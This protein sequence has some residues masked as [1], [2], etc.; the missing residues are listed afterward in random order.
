MALFDVRRDAAIC[1]KLRDQPTLR[2]HGRL[3]V[4]D[5]KR[6][7]PDEFLRPGDDWDTYAWPFLRTRRARSLGAIGDGLRGDLNFRPRY[8]H[9]KSTTPLSR[10]HCAAYLSA[11]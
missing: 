9:A 1:P 6:C 8:N 2:R 10:T 7:D 4:D 3:G 5:P 11:D